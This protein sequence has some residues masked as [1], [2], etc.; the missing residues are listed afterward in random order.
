MNRFPDKRGTDHQGRPKLFYV[1]F[2]STDRVIGQGTNGAV[3]QSM[4][5]EYLKMASREY[6]R[7]TPKDAKIFCYEFHDVREWKVS[8][9]RIRLCDAMTKY[10]M[11]TS[12]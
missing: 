5:D 3:S 9:H 4:K 12:N 11:H 1:T 10:L 7:D 6:L 2:A 8:Q